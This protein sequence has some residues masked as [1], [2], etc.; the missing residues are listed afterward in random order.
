MCAYKL[1]KVDFRYCGMQ[2]T[3]EKSIHEFGKDISSDRICTYFVDGLCQKRD[4][5]MSSFA[6]D[7]VEG[8]SKSVVMAG[9]VVRIVHDRYS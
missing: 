5:F 8:P 7:N 9:R 1:C 6:K 3:L 4:S 2:A